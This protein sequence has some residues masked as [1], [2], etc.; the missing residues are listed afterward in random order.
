MAYKT[1]FDHFSLQQVFPKQATRF[2]KRLERRRR[3]VVEE[4][5]L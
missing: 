1:A 5:V 3:R 2:A 4:T